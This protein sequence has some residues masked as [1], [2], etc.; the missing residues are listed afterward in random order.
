[1][2]WAAARNK[3]ESPSTS[4]LEQTS[5]GRV[6]RLIVT[7]LGQRRVYDFRVETVWLAANP[8]GGGDGKPVNGQ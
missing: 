4:P 6:I 1:M 8:P 3:P 7:L 2:P 5:M